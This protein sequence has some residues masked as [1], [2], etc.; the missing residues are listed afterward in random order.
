MLCRKF[1]R[2][3]VA[4]ANSST[5][6]SSAHALPAFPHIQFAWIHR[7]SGVADARQEMRL[8]GL[9]SELRGMANTIIRQRRCRKGNTLGHR[10]QILAVS[11]FLPAHG[12]SFVTARPRRH[13]IGPNSG[14]PRPR[15]CLLTDLRARL[16]EAAHCSQMR[17]RDRRSHFGPN[18]APPSSSQLHFSVV[19]KTYRQRLKLLRCRLSN[20]NVEFLCL[21]CEGIIRH[22][23]R[24]TRIRRPQQLGRLW[25]RVRC[26]CSRPRSTSR[27]V[28]SLPH[29][30]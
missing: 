22:S 17:S 16:I 26:S 27:K 9:S 3:A 7:R 20:S 11:T 8:G 15:L 2:V 28:G 4:R 6:R 10:F 24:S 19:P 12:H 5:S 1:I 29:D 14:I 25:M 18:A 21:I 30:R 13:V 23:C